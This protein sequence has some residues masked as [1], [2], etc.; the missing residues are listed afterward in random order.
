MAVDKGFIKISGS[1]KYKIASEPWEFEAIHNLNYKTFV[2]EI[3]QH[4]KCLDR[5]LIDKFHD[6]NR[7]LVCVH[8]KI[9]LGMIALRDRRPLSLDQKI[10]NLEAYLP[11]FK[12][13]LEYRLLAIKEEYRNSSVF[14]GLMKMAFNTALR[15]GYDVAVISG[16]ARKARLYGHLGFKPF[17][18]FVGGH[19]AIFQPMYIDIT[20]AFE[21]KKNSRVL[22]G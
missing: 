22:T 15:K 8:G 17:G 16:T 19:G 6:E 12:S 18:P 21:F 10:G 4:K 9:L 2:E 7:Y 3:P 13:I 5:K 1:Y 11:P 14:A 20:S